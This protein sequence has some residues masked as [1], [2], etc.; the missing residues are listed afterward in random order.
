MRY[1]PHL[2]YINSAFRR[3]ALPP[4]DF[5]FDRSAVS[6][7]SE[8]AS[9]AFP[10]MS[11]PET[12]RNRGPSRITNQGPDALIFAQIFLMSARMRSGFPI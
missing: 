10:T 1:G 8:S 12:T 5:F 4:P 7:F 9:S 2:V 3:P 6:S 11:R